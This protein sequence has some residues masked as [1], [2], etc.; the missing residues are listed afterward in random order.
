MRISDNEMYMSK[1]GQWGIMT[2]TSI[3]AKTKYTI[4]K[5]IY[6]YHKQN[7]SQILLVQKIVVPATRVSIVFDPTG[8]QLFIGVPDRNQV[9][10]YRRKNN[11]F[12]LISTIH[13]PDTF[14]D[15]GV[16][17]S[18]SGVL[19][20]D[21]KKIGVPYDNESIHYCYKNRK[22]IACRDIK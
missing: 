21:Y 9:L 22:W 4:D 6:I 17:V 15:F 14:Y 18:L 12:N 20:V 11:V 13:A 10:F 5:N 19:T 8:Q 2:E 3:N 1:N 7:K 16:D